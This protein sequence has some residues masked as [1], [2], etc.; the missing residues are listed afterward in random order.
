MASDLHSQSIE[1]AGFWLALVVVLSAL[2]RF[3]VPLTEAYP[4]NDGGLFYQ[5]TLELEANGWAIPA[6]TGYNL[7]QIPY[8]YPPLAFYLLGFLHNVLGLNLFDLIRVLPPA[9]CLLMLWPVW[10]I[11]KELVHSVPA[12]LAGLAI[13]GL[14]YPG[15]EW[16]IMGGGVT[17]SPGLFFV[18]G[19]LALF[20]RATTLRS[21]KY[22]AGAV[23]SAALAFWVH[24]QTPIVLGSSLLPLLLIRMSKDNWRTLLA[25]VFGLGIVLLPW[26]LFVISRHGLDPLLQAL[27]TGYFDGSALFRPIFIITKGLVYLPLPT[28]LLFFFGILVCAVRRNWWPI[29]WFVLVFIVPRFS[30]ATTMLPI[31]LLSAYGF[32]ALVRARFGL[33]ELYERGERPESRF[34]LATVLLALTIGIQAAMSF[35]ST[36]GLR[37]E[38]LKESDME[39]YRW[40]S[41]NTTPDSKFFIVTKRTGARD[42]LA[43]WFP[44]LTGRHSLLTFE[45]KEWLSKDELYRIYDLRFQVGKALTNGRAPLSATVSD[46]LSAA[47]YLLMDETSRDPRFL[48]HGADVRQFRDL[49]LRKRVE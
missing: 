14:N 13:F 38:T 30:E 32:E 8:A 46:T 45:G 2:V 42:Y 39:A 24:P 9:W 17:R 47:T 21:L 16:L 5:M 28:N 12:R 23:A 34:D 25:F 7:S 10:V 31:A 48:V 37:A 15:Y 3:Y 22:Y 29:G 20:L 1:K 49:A 36:E 26:N 19:C 35:Q 33:G 40:I 27:G 18:Y 11:L 4:V 43:E 6:F 44:A 41:A